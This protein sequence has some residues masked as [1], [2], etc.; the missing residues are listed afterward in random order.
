M[1][2]KVWVGATIVVITAGDG[3]LMDMDIGIGIHACV[4][5]YIVRRWLGWGLGK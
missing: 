4:Y 5:G 2:T 3:G 1:A